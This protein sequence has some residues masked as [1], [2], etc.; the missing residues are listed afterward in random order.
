MNKLGVAVFMPTYNQGNYI[1][2]AIESV[3]AQKTNFQVKLII[4]EDCSTDNTRQ[5]CLDY[6][7]KYPNRIEL[8]L[9]PT[10]DIYSNGVNTHKACQNS[11]LKYIAYCEGDDYWSDPLKLQKQTDFLERNIDY[12]FCTH[13]YERLIDGKVK[14]AKPR[15]D[16]DLNLIDILRHDPKDIDI[17]TLTLLVRNENAIIGNYLKYCTRMLVGDFPITSLAAC[18]GKGRYLSDVMGVYRI[19]SKGASVSITKANNLWFLTRLPMIKL[20]RDKK[21]ISINDQKSF[22]VFYSKAHNYYARQLWNEKRYIPS[23]KHLIH[24]FPFLMFKLFNKDS[25]IIV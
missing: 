17:R 23:V 1:S 9:N 24:S 2:Q 22:K 4:G 10:N 8:L 14:S 6:K 7:E 25:S 19:H 20:I 13:N 5:I 11:G 3:M 16:R 18:H 12:S 21:L 15:T